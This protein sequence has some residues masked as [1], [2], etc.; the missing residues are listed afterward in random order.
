[1]FWLAACGLAKRETSV[2]KELSGVCGTGS[3]MVAVGKSLTVSWVD[4]FQLFPAHQ[5]PG[6]PDCRHLPAPG[7]SCVFHVC[8]NF[9]HFTARMPPTVTS[10]LRSIIM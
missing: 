7:T 4:P 10:L 1:M 9:L 2:T 3:T 5:V 6:N 8:I